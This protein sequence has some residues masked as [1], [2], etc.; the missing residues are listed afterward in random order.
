MLLLTNCLKGVLRQFNEAN[1]LMYTVP[2]THIHE[3]QPVLVLCLVLPATPE[4]GC[5]QAS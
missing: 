3:V 1:D 2:C 4:S 5:Y